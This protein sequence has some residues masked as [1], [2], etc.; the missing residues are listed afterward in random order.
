MT[1]T[2]IFPTTNISLID[3]PLNG[4]NCLFMTA[5]LGDN[6]IIFDPNSP[7]LLS[8]GKIGGKKMKAEEIRTL[9]NFPQ[10]LTRNEFSRNDNR[11][12]YEDLYTVATGMQIF[13]TDSTGE[14]KALIAQN[15]ADK[16]VNPSRYNFSASGLFSGGNF[17]HAAAQSLS[18]E[19]G[20]VV[21]TGDASFT[22]LILALPS[23][24]GNVAFDD[25]KQNGKIITELKKSSDFSAVDETAIQIKSL[26]LSLTFNENAQQN[27]KHIQIVSY[28]KQPAIMDEVNNIQYSSFHQ[29]SVDVYGHLLAD[30]D[31][32]SINFHHVM[33]LRLPEGITLNDIIPLDMQGFGKNYHLLSSDEVVERDLIPAPRD[34][35]GL[36]PA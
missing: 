14:T 16:P 4:N 31:K 19:V 3:S 23:V 27:A 5:K 12:G 33:D 21:K 18:D 1:I 35:F 25:T 36:K 6:K 34:F 10:I 24:F 32:R 11:T 28:K 29:E 7:L 30:N 8:D 20:L 26:P 9:L 13:I 15:S 22:K 17:M 2:Q